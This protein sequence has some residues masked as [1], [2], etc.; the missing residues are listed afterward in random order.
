MKLGIAL[1]VGGLFILWIIYE[2]I[3]APLIEDG[4]EDEDIR[5]RLD[6]S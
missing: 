6:E 3:T 2:V 5:Q 4:P 1:I